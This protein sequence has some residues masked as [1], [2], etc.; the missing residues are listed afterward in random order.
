MEEKKF[1]IVLL[2]DGTEG[3]KW[4]NGSIT[5]AKGHIVV[6]SKNAVKIVTSE[7][8]KEMAGKRHERRKEVVE[9]YVTKAVIE[10]GKVGKRKRGA[11]MS[12]D[13]L[14]MIV[15]ARVKVAMKD[16]GRAGNDAARFVFQVLDAMP[17]DKDKNTVVH[18]HELSDKT[19][20]LLRELAK[21]SNDP[22]FEYLE[23][24]EV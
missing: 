6:P 14:G 1:E 16:D 23:G 19:V 2:P 17:S 18:Q 3:K 24:K 21:Q 9:Q 4:E 10:H 8:A 15:A 22:D 13:A 5:N 7:Q 12:D 20:A 11:F